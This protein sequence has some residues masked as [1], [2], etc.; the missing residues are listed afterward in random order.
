[1][2]LLPAVRPHT[3]HSASLGPISSCKSLGETVL[4]TQVTEL[5][6]LHEVLRTASSTL[7]TPGRSVL[8]ILFVIPHNGEQP[9]SVNR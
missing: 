6:G 7:L 5:R 1:M 8:Q 9:R 3:S 4:I 2:T